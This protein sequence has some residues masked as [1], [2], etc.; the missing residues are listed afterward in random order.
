MKSVSFRTFG[1]LLVLE[2]ALRIL[3]MSE[4]SPRAMTERHRLALQPRWRIRERV[5][6]VLC[7]NEARR[8]YP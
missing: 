3:T 2:A 4:S 5:T 6:H 8:Y 1:W 7:L